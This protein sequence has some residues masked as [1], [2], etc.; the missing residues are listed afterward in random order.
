MGQLWDGADWK[1]DDKYERTND[2][3]STRLPVAGDARL[4]RIT[5]VQVS[6][7]VRRAGPTWV[8][9]VRPSVFK[10]DNPMRE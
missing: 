8:A 2:A 10:Q 1:L 9:D 6:A 5:H 4:A 3:N 7:E